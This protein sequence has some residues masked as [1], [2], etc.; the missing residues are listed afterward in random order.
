M[1]RVPRQAASLDGAMAGERGPVAALQ[2]AHRTARR[3]V[4]DGVPWLVYELPTMVFDRRNS[5]SLVFE[6]DVAIRRV[7]KFPPHWRALEDEEL[8]AL[9]W[10]P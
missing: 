6:S 10:S 9:S 1:R 2:D 5:P 8:F 3:L 7:R 4:V